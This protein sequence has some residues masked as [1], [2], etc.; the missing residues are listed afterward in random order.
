MPK[1]LFIS[2]T[3]GNGLSGGSMI[4]RRNLNF[5]RQIGSGSIQVTALC[6]G[7]TVA[8]PE[9]NVE[10]VSAYYS[11]AQT[12]LAALCL[13]TGGL[14]K[15]S[16]DKIR[17]L[18]SDHHFDVL[19]LDSSL[20]GNIAKIAK[21]TRPKIKVISYFHNVEL[22]YALERC[23]IES[24]KF[25]ALIPAIYYAERASVKYSDIIVG[26]SDRDSNLLWDKYRRSF[27]EIIP[28]SLPDRFAPN[29]LQKVK[30]RTVLFV[31]SDFYA[32]VHG[33]NWLVREVMCDQSI[34]IRLE[35]VGSGL[36]K[37]RSTFSRANIDIIGK[38]SNIDDYYY[39]AN[40]VIM[41][42]FSGSGMKVKT[43]E[44]LSF[45][46]HV[47]GSTE[48]FIGYDVDRL[49]ARLCTSADDF[50]TALADIGNIPDNGFSSTNRRSFELNYSDEQ[51]FKTFSNLFKKVI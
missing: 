27:D 25:S 26:I 50:K 35:V 24:L 44:A 48:A 29:K 4:G 18:I 7:R 51:S 32:N 13:K 46:R 30:P 21:D 17:Q 40:A 45:G 12:L 39:Q 47:I 8:N 42:I 34:D 20:L 33:L 49:D 16:E 2:G 11:P 31:G 22:E 3:I 37:Y 36:E 38:V 5:V 6:T 9:L 28:V 43:A 41:P 15:K 23:R 1:L 10:T 19:F 14:T